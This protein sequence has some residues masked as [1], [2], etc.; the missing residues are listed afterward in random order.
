MCLQSFNHASSLV[1]KVTDRTLSIP[2]HN[3]RARRSEACTNSPLPKSN[4][5]SK[6]YADSMVSART[7]SSRQGLPETGMHRCDTAILNRARHE[8]MRHPMKLNCPLP[9]AG[10]DP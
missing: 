7:P 1:T 2:Q 9:A 6:N 4:M 3:A 10:I 5:K 8:I